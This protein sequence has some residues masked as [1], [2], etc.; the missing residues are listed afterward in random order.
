MNNVKAML[1]I[2]TQRWLLENQK[3]EKEKL[4]AV[5]S[6]PVP[7]L[8]VTPDIGLLHP[9]LTTKDGTTRFASNPK[10][11]KTLSIALAF[12]GVRYDFLT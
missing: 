11:C 2:I 1:Q 3:G 12:I 7:Q 9:L 5:E 4:A 8:E 6:L 10:S